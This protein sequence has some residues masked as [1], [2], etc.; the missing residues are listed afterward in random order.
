LADE[1]IA[2]LD[3]ESS[4]LVM[5]ILKKLNYEEGLTV[6]VSLHQV[7]YALKYCSRAVALGFGRVLFDG[8]SHLLTVEKMKSIYGHGAAEMFS[9]IKTENPSSESTGLKVKTGK[10][11]PNTVSD[12][13]SE[14]FYHA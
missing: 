3:P 10:S 2:S 9:H 4:I 5:E 13:I 1:P 12:P 7:D 8:P 11:E 6:L 14:N